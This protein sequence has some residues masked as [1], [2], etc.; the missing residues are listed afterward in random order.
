MP[1]HKKVTSLQLSPLMQVGPYDR[2]D[3]VALQ[4]VAAGVGDSFQQKRAIE[5]II[6]KLCDFHGVS[7]RETDR[8]TSFAEGKRF[9]AQ[10]INA[11]LTFDAR[12]LEEPNN[13]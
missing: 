8:E 11:V 2:A 4:N 13:G 5:F 12:K 9:I 3:I 10:G 6:Y 1:R 7:F